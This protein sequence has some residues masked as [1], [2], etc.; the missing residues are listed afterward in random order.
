MLGVLCCLVLGLQMPGEHAHRCTKPALLA[1]CA[2]LQQ[3][4]PKVA[5]SV[6]THSTAAHMRASCT[7]PCMLCH[8]GFS[9]ALASVLAAFYSPTVEG[10]L[11]GGRTWGLA[12][13]AIGLGSMLFE[14][15]QVLLLEPHSVCMLARLC[16]MQRHSLHGSNSV[17]SANLPAYQHAHVQATPHAWPQCRVMP[18]L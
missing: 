18:L 11:A 13:L 2:T 10:V 14:T 3:L 17:N 8:V 6:A 4:F 12:F 16:V 5:T 15:L 9:L 1:P 7:M